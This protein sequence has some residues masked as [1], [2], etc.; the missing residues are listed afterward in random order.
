MPTFTIPHIAVMAN[1]PDHLARH[2]VWRLAKDG[3]VSPSTPR[4]N[5]VWTPGGRQRRIKFRFST[6]LSLDRVVGLLKTMPV[7][8]HT[9]ATN[10]RLQAEARMIAD[11]LAELTAARRS[12]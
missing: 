3:W 5:A 8:P 6:P 12:K 10:P 2:R 4:E 11:R 1:L 7:H 9:G